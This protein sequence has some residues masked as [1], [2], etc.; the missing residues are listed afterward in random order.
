MTPRDPFEHM[1]N[2]NPVPPGT[3][4]SAPMSMADRIVGARTGWPGW[5]MGVGAAAAVLVIGFVSILLIDSGDDVVAG[6]DTTS[7]TD[8]TPTSVTPTTETT[9]PSTATSAATTTT[10]TSAPAGEVVVYL[11][12]DDPTATGPSPA[13]VPVARPLATLSSSPIDEPAAAIGFLLAGPTPGE[14]A[15]TPRLSSEIPEATRFLGLTI[16][17]GVATVDLSGEFATAS[18]T[19]SEIARIEQLV[20]TLTRFDDIDGIRLEL[21]GVLIGVFGGHGIVLD[22][23]AVRTPLDTLLPAIMIESP[24]YG[25]IQ[26]DSLASGGVVLASGS[27]NVF[28][29]TVSLALTD[30]DGLILWE[31]FTTA[32]CGTGCRGDW[33]VAITYEVD[34]PQMGALIVWEQSMQDGSQINV[35]EHPVWLV[36]GPTSA[37]GAC[38]GAL[39]EDALIP[40]LDLPPEVAATRTALF[41]AAVIC[42]WEALRDL[43]GADVMFSFGAVTED[44]IANW[45][46]LEETLDAQPMRYLAELLNRSYGT[47][48]GPEGLRYFA[49]PSAFVVAWEDVTEAQREELRPLF[50]DEDFAVFDDFGGYIG[51][52]IGILTDGTWA[53]F[54]AGD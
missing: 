18:G 46:R 43:G 31:G 48:P 22:D 42:D 27:A 39:V 8:A 41:H 7:T 25:S 53:Y 45:Q 24:A 20:Y 1:K 2:T 14:S 33:E 3:E 17:N 10:V 50:G 38:S 26:P 11:L 30:A 28:E 6:G 4:P 52:R 37:P 36:P 34:E 13:L 40:Q 12:V 35:R 44:A 29:A 54:V 32:S 51:D 15:G 9:I 23:P 16:E 21:D 47:Q 19:L 5:A 49:W